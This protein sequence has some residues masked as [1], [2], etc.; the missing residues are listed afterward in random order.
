MSHETAANL[1]LTH[2]RSFTRC[3]DNGG[4]NTS[5]LIKPHKKKSQGVMFRH[6]GGHFNNALSSRP[7]QPIQRC[8]RCSIRYL[9]TCHYGNEVAPNHRRLNMPSVAWWTPC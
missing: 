9:R 6:L 2:P 8:G 4:K 3:R 5:F 7:V 1:F